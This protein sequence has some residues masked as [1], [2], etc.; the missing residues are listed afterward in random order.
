MIRSDEVSQTFDSSILQRN[1]C[2]P[3]RTALAIFLDSFIPLT[4]FSTVLTCNSRQSQLYSLS[5]LNIVSTLFSVDFALRMSISLFVIVQRFLITF[6]LF[7]MLSFLSISMVEISSQ[8]HFSSRASLPSNRS[9][10]RM[11]NHVLEV[12]LSVISQQGICRNRNKR[13]T[14]TESQDW[15]FLLLFFIQHEH[16]RESVLWILKWGIQCAWGIQMGIG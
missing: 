15:C 7:Y 3:R 16:V 14:Q 9:R 2:S 5:S 11:I 8:F 10:K 13:G 4:W 1:I 12:C 6:S